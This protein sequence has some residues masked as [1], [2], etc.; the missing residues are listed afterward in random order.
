MLR[1]L[2]FLFIECFGWWLAEG[3]EIYLTAGDRVIPPFFSRDENLYINDA[4]NDAQ[5]SKLFFV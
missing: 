4:D 3:A 5:L 2:S 1:Y